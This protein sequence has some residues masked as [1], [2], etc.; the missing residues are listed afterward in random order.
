MQ[1]TVIISDFEQEKMHL[2]SYHYELGMVLSV[3]HALSHSI[4]AVAFWV[5]TMLWFHKNVHVLI[6]RTYECIELYRKE[7]SAEV[8]KVKV[9]RC[10]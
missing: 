5:Q 7:D 9:L 3:L 2:M 6:L 4:L 8:V 10:A 1:A